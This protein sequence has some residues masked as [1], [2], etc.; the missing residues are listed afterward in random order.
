MSFNLGRLSDG[1]NRLRRDFVELS[2]L[3]LAVREDWLDQRCAKFENDHLT[4]IGP[5][6]NR[7]SGSLTQFCEAVRKAEHAL[8]DDHPGSGRLD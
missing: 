2:R 5:S 6:L 1:E 8:K 3:W 7:L 4:T